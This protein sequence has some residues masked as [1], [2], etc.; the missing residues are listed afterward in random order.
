MFLQPK[1]GTKGKNQILEENKQTLNFYLYIIAGANVSVPL[2]M[3][4]LAYL[5]N[6]SHVGVMM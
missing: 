3:P 4:N 6:W 5:E 2:M 1:Q